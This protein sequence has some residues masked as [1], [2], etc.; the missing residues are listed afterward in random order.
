MKVATPAYDPTTLFLPDVSLNTRD[1]L[2][3]TAPLA[4][5]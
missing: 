2:Q 5:L 4:G 3:G 1:A